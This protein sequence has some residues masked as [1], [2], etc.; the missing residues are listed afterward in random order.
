MTTYKLSNPQLA[1][2]LALTF[3]LKGYEACGSTLGMGSLEAVEEMNIETIKR[4]CVLQK[5][6]I[7]EGFTRIDADYLAGRMMK[8]RISYS[9]DGRVVIDDRTPSPD[10][11]GWASGQPKHPGIPI[12]PSSIGKFSSYLELLQAAAVDCK[13]ELEPAM[14]KTD[15]LALSHPGTAEPPAPDVSH[16]QMT[17]HELPANAAATLAAIIREVDSTHDFGSVALANAILAHPASQ[18]RPALPVPTDAEL[19]ADFV[20]WYKNTYGELPLGS[21]P[22]NDVIKLARYLLQRW[23][24]QLT[25][26]PPTLAT[27]RPQ[28]NEEL[29]NWLVQEVLS[30]S[31]NPATPSE[32]STK[33]LTVS[34]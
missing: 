34:E 16:C 22:S 12:L 25:A 10:D 18:W 20:V 4:H 32:T 19:R 7:N 3:M 21:P 33:P 15:Q 9:T 14:L 23:S 27:A 31:A 30:A 8:T 6:Y 29:I 17:T 1:E 28:I 24:P 13:I 5:D 2:Q 26:P 11:Q